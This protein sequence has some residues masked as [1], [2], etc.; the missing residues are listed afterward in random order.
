M[1]VT[2]AR[3]TPVN[4]HL[5]AQQKLFLFLSQ[6]EDLLGFAFDVAFGAVE[7]TFRCYMLL[8]QQKSDVLVSFRS[9]VLFDLS[10]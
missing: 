4:Y 2:L 5:K 9:L 10:I 7:K 1:M 6:S 3:R 8:L